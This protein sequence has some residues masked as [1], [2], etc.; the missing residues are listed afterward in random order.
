M[1]VGSTGLGLFYASK[2]GEPLFSGQPDWH[3]GVAVVLPD[4]DVIGGG[5]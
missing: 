2:L 5:D 4:V 1:A 3:V